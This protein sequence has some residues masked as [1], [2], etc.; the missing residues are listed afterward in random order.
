MKCPL[1]SDPEGSISANQHNP[2]TLHQ[3]PNSG[4]AD[5]WDNV[6]GNPRELGLAAHPR[7]ACTNFWKYQDGNFRNQFNIAYMKVSDFCKNP[8]CDDTNP[9][10]WLGI[11]IRIH[12]FQSNYCDFFHQLWKFFKNWQVLDQWY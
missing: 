11:L 4:S 6:N 1:V 10:F 8:N 7:V 3:K 2:N 5:Q 9:Y 12:S